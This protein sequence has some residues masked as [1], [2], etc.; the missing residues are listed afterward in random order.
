MHGQLR[1]KKAVGRAG[2]QSNWDIQQPLV[3]ILLYGSLVGS[4]SR[5]HAVHMGVCA[6]GPLVG[7]ERQD[8]GVLTV[9]CS[10]SVGS[11]LSRV[12]RLREFL[13][14]S[15]RVRRYAHSGEGGHLGSGTFSGCITMKGTVTRVERGVSWGIAYK[16]EQRNGALK[17]RKTR[18]STR[19]TEAW[20]QGGRLQRMAA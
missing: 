18:D 10:F 11:S 16:A 2:T 14:G 9:G 3:S 13:V 6:R 4:I 19:G 15:F 1:Y 12:C 17:P 8:I 20:V 7:G 5:G